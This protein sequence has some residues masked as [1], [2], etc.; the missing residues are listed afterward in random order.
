MK[1]QKICEILKAKKYW[2]SIGLFVV[3]FIVL[4]VKAKKGIPVKESILS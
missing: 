1:N 4:K 2:D 3:I